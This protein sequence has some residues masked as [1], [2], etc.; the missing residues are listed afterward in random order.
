MFFSNTF[1]SAPPSDAILQSIKNCVTKSRHS[2]HVGGHAAGLVSRG[3]PL[4]PEKGAG[5]ARLLQ[6]RTTVGFPNIAH[7]RSA[8]GNVIVYLVYAGF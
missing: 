5:H 6:A 2:S 4:F 8:I 1:N 3:Q 7:L